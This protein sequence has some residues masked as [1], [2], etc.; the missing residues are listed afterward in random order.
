MSMIDLADD[1]HDEHPVIR[2][3]TAPLFDAA[4][5]FRDAYMEY[6]LNYPIAAYRIDD[7]MAN[8][9][10][11]KTFVDQSIQHPDAHRL[12]IKNFINRPIPR[13][14]RHEPLLKGIMD[15]TPAIH[16]DREAIPQVLEI[17]KALCKETEPGVQSTKQKVQLWCYNSNMQFKPNES[18]DMDLSA[19]QA[20]RVNGTRA[21]H[22]FSVGNQ[23]RRTLV[24]YTKKKG[25]DSAFRVLEPVVEKINERSK[26]PVSFTSHT[27]CAFRVVPT[28]QGVLPALEIWSASKQKSRFFAPK[29]SKSW[30]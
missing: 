25:L 9:I 29:A 14:L 11:F 6:I 4:L 10:D 18:V 30:V 16:E 1:S 24:I 26:A 19:Y 17:I 22:F 13:S 3:I 2:S 23:G 28:V 27:A 12:D 15:E 21:V 8:N 5:N 7:E 20:L